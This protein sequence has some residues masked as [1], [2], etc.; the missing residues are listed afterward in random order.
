MNSFQNSPGDD[1]AGQVDKGSEGA[2]EALIAQGQ[3]AK[4][5]LEPGEEALHRPLAAQ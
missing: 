3:S 2:H 1:E 4:A 5:S